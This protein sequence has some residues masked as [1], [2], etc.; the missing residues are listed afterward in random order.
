[1]FSFEHLPENMQRISAVDFLELSQFLQLH[2]RESQ[3][4]HQAQHH[5]SHRTDRKF[6]SHFSSRVL[7]LLEGVVP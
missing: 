2:R 6:R 7:L 4:T 5:T 1:M 3:P